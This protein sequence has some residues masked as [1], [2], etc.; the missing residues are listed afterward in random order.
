M[1]IA[2]IPV[3]G[4]GF[5]VILISMKWHEDPEELKKRRK[6]LGVTQAELS[7]K[8]GSTPE[9]IANI[10]AGR[11]PLTGPVAHAI[12]E[13]LAQVD[14]ERREMRPLKD[15]WIQDVSPAGKLIP[16]SL[17][18]RFDRE[19]LALK[20]SAQ[21]LLHAHS[22]LIKTEDQ[23]WQLYKQDEGQLTDY[24]K[25][26]RL[27]TIEILHDTMRRV[28]ENLKSQ[29]GTLEAITGKAGERPTEPTAERTEEEKIHG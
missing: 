1:L 9:I 22:T 8:C 17:E 15:Q 29:V 24:Q 26:V 12:W 13:A 3:D 14:Q 5:G 20:R 18:Q 21:D 11:R 7:V 10:E 2:F 4:A 25:E 23:L 27:N 16:E 28:M 6:S 19:A